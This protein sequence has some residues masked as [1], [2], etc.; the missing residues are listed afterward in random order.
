M[1][2][3]HYMPDERHARQLAEDL[4]WLYGAPLNLRVIDE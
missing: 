2:A 4:A 1:V 3:V